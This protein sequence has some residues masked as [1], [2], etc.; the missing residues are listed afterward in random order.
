MREADDEIVISLSG[1]PVFRTSTAAPRYGEPFDE[2]VGCW[3]LARL[4]DSVTNPDSL[5]PEADNFREHGPFESLEDAKEEAYRT[6]RNI[7]AFV[8]DPTQEQR[9][10]LQHCLGYFLENRK[11]LD[12]INGAFVL[13]LVQLP[14]VAAVTAILKNESMERSRWIV[15]NPDLAPL[16]QA[17]ILANPQEGERIVRDLANRFGP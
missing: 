12:T 17:V 3:L 9:G 10:P 2:V 16:E 14:Q 4:H 1:E 13:A 7:L 11:T 8:Y 15:F 6:R 5:P